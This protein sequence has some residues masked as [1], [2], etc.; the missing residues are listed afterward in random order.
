MAGL[1]IDT[2]ILR[3]LVSVAEQ[4]NSEI[5]EAAQ[6]LNAIT[7]HEDW[8]CSERDKIKEMTI[9]NKQKAQNIE[10]NSSSFYSAVQTSSE[11]F[12]TT[13]QDSTRR[14]NSVDD[15]IGGISSIVPKISES[16]SIDT[17]SGSGISIMDFQGVAGS[18]SG[19][20]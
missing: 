4:T 11:K 16:V 9:S 18:A 6:L 14:Q 20:E 10:D 5:E 15:I 13:E 8:R 17:V 1:N 7:V 3:N 12:D 19:E 2:G